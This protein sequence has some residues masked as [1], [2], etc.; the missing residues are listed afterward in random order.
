MFELNKGKIMK[1]KLFTITCLIMLISCSTIF[2]RSLINIIYD[3]QGN[4]ISLYD[5]HTWSMNQDSFNSAIDLSEIEGNF[6]IKNDGMEDFIKIGLIED[7]IYPGSDDW[8]E[9]LGMI[10]LVMNLYSAEDLLGGDEFSIKF[11]NN[12][13]SVIT[14]DTDSGSFCLNRIDPNSDEI[15]YYIQDNDLFIKGDFGELIELGTFKDSNTLDV[16]YNS[17]MGDED[18]ALLL[19]DKYSKITLEK[20]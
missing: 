2:G 17:F 5:D 14:Q 7:G 16:D 12:Q 13:L 11:E 10:G 3:G 9:S 1:K 15:G 8:I 4:K 19:Y 18:S 6:I 20:E